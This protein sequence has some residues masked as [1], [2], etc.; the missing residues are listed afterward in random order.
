MG[1]ADECSLFVVPVLVGGGKH[2]LP[3]TVRANWWMS[4]GCYP[5]WSMFD[6]ASTPDIDGTVA[7]LL[8]VVGAMLTAMSWPA[9]STDCNRR[10]Q[11]DGTRARF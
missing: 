6:T 5:V 8:A 1:L 3:D 9:R 11:E 10:L 7:T 2:A 4:A